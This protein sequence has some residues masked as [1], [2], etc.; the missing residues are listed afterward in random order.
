MINNYTNR[1]VRNIV[2]VYDYCYFNG[3]AAKVAIESACALSEQQGIYVFFFGA[4]GPVC[5]ELQNSTVQTKCLY[6]QDINSGNRLVAAKNGI[7]NTKAKKAFIEFIKP[8]NPENTI[9]HFHGWAK[10]LSS[11]IIQAASSRKFTC[12]VT[13]HD[14]FC[15]CPNGGFYN[16]ID[17][18]LCKIKPMSLKCIVCNCDKRNYIQK[19]WRVMRQFVQDFNVRRNKNII[20]ISISELNEQLIRPYV[21]SNNFQ[22]VYNLIEIDN[23]KNGDLESG[24]NNRFICVGRIS[25]EKGTEL[26]CA[27][28]SELM[29]T[30]NI[31][32]TVIGD[33]ALLP[34]LKLRFPRI[35]FIG[36]KSM[37][38]VTDY[39]RTSRALVFP[40]KC[41]EGA[42]LT[43]VES[44]CN[45]LPCIVS[46]CTSATELIREGYNGFIFETDNCD[47]LKKKIIESLSD[48]KIQVMKT[49]I[50]NDFDPNAYSKNTHLDRLME[51]YQTALN[52]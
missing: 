37:D 33:G 16:Y 3:G 21:K 29:A 50:K 34:D 26:F 41:Y 11:S 44:L 35:C 23:K 30:V 39:M 20:F 5:N 25:E 12:L 40:S 31:E 10:A 48:E 49:N 36:W 46:D 32:G 4:V 45:E 7:W 8:F 52:K 22:R 38:E 1:T 42:P 27:A 6:M 17:K 19:I 2:I 43:I 9:I 13:L 14:Y 47:S 24:F 18:K 28:I 15:V 51:L